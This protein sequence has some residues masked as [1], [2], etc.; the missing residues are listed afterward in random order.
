M[1]VSGAIVD[2]V[3]RVSLQAKAADYREF[4]VARFL[5]PEPQDRGEPAPA[6]SPLAPTARYWRVASSLVIS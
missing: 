6:G 4:Q 5:S 3:R 1:D 2:A